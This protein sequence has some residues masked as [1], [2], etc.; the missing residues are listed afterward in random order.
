MNY[1]QREKE[2]NIKKG[3]PNL[4][5]RTQ[6]TKKAMITIQLVHTKETTK[7]CSAFFNFTMLWCVA[8]VKNQLLHVTC[9]IMR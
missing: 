4:K 2:P 1:E 8:S 9:R 7:T 5:S 6:V 3:R